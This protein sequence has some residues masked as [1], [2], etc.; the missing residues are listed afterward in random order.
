M[1]S[2]AGLK[3]CA[4]RKRKAPRLLPGEPVIARDVLHKEPA[5]AA[6]DELD[7]ESIQ[8]GKLGCG[9]CDE[10]YFP[11]AVHVG[12]KLAVRDRDLDDSGDDSP[13]RGLLHI[14]AD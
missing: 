7:P 14:G 12:E 1:P 13:E 10:R 11:S 9:R 2:Q 8:T 5:G 4:T 6:L 3:S